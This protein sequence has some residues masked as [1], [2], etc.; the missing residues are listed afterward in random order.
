MVQSYGAKAAFDYRSPTCVDDIQAYTNNSIAHVL[1]CISTLPSMA[2]CYKVIKPSSSSST[3]KSKYTALEPY[4]TRISASYSDVTADWVLLLTQFGE[5]VG[6]N[7]VYAREARPQD[8]VWMKHWYE[9]VER[10]ILEK[11]LRPHPQE[12]FS[13]SGL[14]PIISGLER[15]KSGKVSGTKLVYRVT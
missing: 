14:L 9:V 10:L 6:L 11:K 15:L 7:G 3:T 2:L 1:D 4:S 12:V 13:S 5:S 8:R